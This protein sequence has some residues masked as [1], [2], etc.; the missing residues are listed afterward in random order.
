M[1]TSLRPEADLREEFNRRRTSQYISLVPIVAVAAAMLW[2]KEQPGSEFAGITPN[3]FS[4]VVF[5]V[6]IAVGGFSF[7]NWRCPSCNSYLGRAASP[8]FCGRCGF[9]LREP[10]A[11]S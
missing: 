2:L 4:L 1:E 10:P 5:A 8:T 9:R 3:V 6:V 7:F 11:N